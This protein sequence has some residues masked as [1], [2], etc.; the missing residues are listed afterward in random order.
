[1]VKHSAYDVLSVWETAFRWNGSDPDVPS[2]P[3]PAPVR[4]TLS[5]LALVTRHTLNIYDSQ[6]EPE[7]LE[8]LPFLLKDKDTSKL[9]R[10]L[11]KCIAERD[12]DRAVFDR[13]FLRKEEVER[14]CLLNNFALP[15]FWFRDDEVAYFESLRRPKWRNARPID[16][17]TDQPLEVQERKAPSKVPPKPGTRWDNERRDRMACHAKARE[18]WAKKPN[19]TIAEII[20]SKEIRQGCNGAQYKPATLHRWVAEVDSRRLEQKRGRP[21]KKQ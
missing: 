19:L 18:M 10:A 3:L 11:Q 21:K 4:E 2:E 9:K 7:L 17:L 14:W 13:V 20:G 6:G 5:K 15:A 1:V 8:L 12:Y 16:F